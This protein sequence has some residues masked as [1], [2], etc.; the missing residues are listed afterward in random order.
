MLQHEQL[1]IQ[2]LLLRGVRNTNDPLAPL[3]IDYADHSDSELLQADLLHTKGV[4]EKPSCIM[5]SGLIAR[6]V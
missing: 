4:K 6:T 5:L 3:S 2:Y 1:L